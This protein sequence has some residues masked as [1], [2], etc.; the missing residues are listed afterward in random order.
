MW[1]PNLTEMS[2]G[3]L[4]SLFRFILW[5]DWPERIF[6]W[7][8]LI[9]AAHIIW[10]HDMVGYDMD[11]DTYSWQITS[12]PPWSILLLSKEPSNHVIF[13]EYK[14][15]VY[16]FFVILNKCYHYH[17]TKI[18]WWIRPLLCLLS[19][20]SGS[21]N[22]CLRI[23]TI[24][25]TNDLA[26]FGPFRKFNCFPGGQAGTQ[27]SWDFWWIDPRR[28][29]NNLLQKIS[30]RNPVN[31]SLEGKSEGADGAKSAIATAESGSAIAIVRCQTVVTLLSP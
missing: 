25:G 27:A 13:A 20:S 14:R 21:G 22:N 24:C 26:E 1:F 28:A 30:G 12:R 8:T 5:S 3:F 31:T 29:N 23:L 6:S 10:N 11:A 2:N 18:F 16:L 9:H 4:Q 15:N 17:E 7:I 19:G